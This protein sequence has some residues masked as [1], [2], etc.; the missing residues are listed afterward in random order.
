MFVWR[1]CR[2]DYADLSGIG[3]SLYGGRWNSPAHSVIYTASSL[4]L[5]FVEI[6]PGL[7]RN[8]IP[9]GFVS[10]YISIKTTVSKKELHLNDFPVNWEKEKTGKWFIETGNQWLQEKKELLLVVPSV[11]IPEEQNILINPH[12]PEIKNVEIKTIKPFRVDPRFIV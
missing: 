9:K 12:H 3:A 8:R 7:R 5:A 10:L 6:I 2:K 4:A 11:I 1:L